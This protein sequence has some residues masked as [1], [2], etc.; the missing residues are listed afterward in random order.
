MR[1]KFILLA[2]AFSQA[3]ALQER[4]EIPFLG[5]QDAYTPGV[6]RQS[7][8]G[9]G[10]IDI[11]EITYSGLNTFAGVAH[12]QCFRPSHDEKDATRYDIAVL[13]APLDTTVTGRPG[14]RYGPSSIRTGSSRKAWGFDFYTGR[15]P[16][17]SWAK[18]VDCGDAPLTWLDNRAAIRTLDQAHRR[19]ANRPP[20]DASKS[21]VPR[22]ITLGGD[23]TTTLSALRGT[24]DN[25]GEVSVVHFD[26]HIDTWDPKVLGGGI[27]D[28]ASVNH[29]TFLHIAHEE[30]LIRNSSMHVG[31]RASLNRP[32]GDMKNDRRCGFGTITARDLDTYGIQGVIDQIRSRV[33]NTRVYITVD[34]DVL[35]PAFAPATGTPEVGGWST[36]ELLAILEGLGGLEIIG[37]D[38]VE[39]SPPFDNHGETTALAAA[40]IVHNLIDLMVLTPIKSVEHLSSGPK[41]N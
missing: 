6:F 41:S 31:I 29:G 12:A 27:S 34:I 33:K 23:H 32:K 14:A 28:Y 36:R 5:E 18:I 20:A 13:G 7:S 15:N 9:E 26:S 11:S 2:P 25:W 35:D 38:V 10:P 8:A 17:K 3:L 22:I 4:R 37:A 30:G 1:I 40:E 16:L 19:T 24:H 39:V 21:H